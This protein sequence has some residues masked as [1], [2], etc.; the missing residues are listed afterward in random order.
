MRLLIQVFLIFFVITII[1][2]IV[3]SLIAPST[4]VGRA[5][6][7]PR[8]SVT[9]GKLVKDPV[10]GTYVAE[11]SSLQAGGNSFCSEECRQK[12]ISQG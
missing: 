11:E 9:T 4:P 8:R 3:R 7:G 6:Q 5:P 1:L 12:F 2:S 10:C